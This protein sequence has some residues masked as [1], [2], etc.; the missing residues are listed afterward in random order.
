MPI[1]GNLENKI[2]SSS[3][4]AQT[5]PL[6]A[7]PKEVKQVVKEP[8]KT[9]SNNKTLWLGAAAV[10]SLAI[11]GIAIARGRKVKPSAGDNP[12]LQKPKHSPAATRKPKIEPQKPAAAENINNKNTGNIDNAGKT[13]TEQPVEVKQPVII[14]KLI[15]LDEAAEKLRLAAELKIRGEISK[16]YKAFKK[17]GMDSMNFNHRAQRIVRETDSQP[18]ADLRLL[19]TED[20]KAVTSYQRK[21]QYNAKLRSG[22]DLSDV[23]EIKRLDRIIQD[24]VPLEE[25]AYVYRGIRTQKIWDDFS[26]LDFA[27]DLAEGNILEDKAYVSTSRVYGDLLAQVDPHNFSEHKSSGYVMRIKL[28][29]GTKGLDCR[30]SIGKDLD[31]G[32]NAEFI[33]PRNSQFRIVAVD[34]NQRILEC[35][36]ILPAA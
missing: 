34:K 9:S 36:Y 4:T 19:S 32:Y 20:C 26:E 5:K 8:E 15:E 10:A 31:G 23:E 12:F 1:L 21:Y 28:P 16:F 17:G 29:K 30:R 25:E 11:A 33:L 3:V 22:A 14:N 6:E 18:L 7:K 35:E 27:K 2:I 13:N 24:A